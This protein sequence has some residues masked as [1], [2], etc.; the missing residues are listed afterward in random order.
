M[1]FNYLYFEG[2]FLPIVPLKLKG[3]N[4][5]IE[6]QAFIDTGASYSLF[7][8][9]VAEVLGLELEKGRKE[10]M[11]LGDGDILTVFV[12][13][14][15]VSVAGKEFLAKIGFSKGIGVNLYIIGRKDI[16]ERFIVS[17]NEKEKW[18]EFNDYQ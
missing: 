15:E 7:P 4:G 18:V 11:V 12:F 1:R 8:A 9:D 5:F 6:F 17:F 14:I 13:N 2:K 16:F 10:E 3:T